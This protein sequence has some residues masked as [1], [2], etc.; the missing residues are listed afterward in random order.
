MATMF[1]DAYE[2]LYTGAVPALVVPEA[3]LCRAF[4]IS[5]MAWKVLCKILAVGDNEA[6]DCGVYNIFM[7]DRRLH[8]LFSIW[9]S[10]LLVQLDGEAFEFL[11]F[12]GFALVDDNGVVHDNMLCASDVSTDRP[13]LDVKRV[14]CDVCVEC[15]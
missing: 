3:D 11:R 10:K 8:M 15:V 9:D 13:C 12:C 7:K 6:K 5:T 14:T 2:Q 1:G 4:S